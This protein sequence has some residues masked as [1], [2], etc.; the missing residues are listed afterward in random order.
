MYR[1]GFRRRRGWF[2]LLLAVVL[3]A[4]VENPVTGERELGF[5][6]TAQQIA[7]GE[8]QYVPAQQ[9]QGGQYVVDPQLSA[10]VQRVGE[11]VAA[12]SGIDLP[13]EFVV[14]NSSVPNAWALPGGK[15]AINRGLLTELSNEAE[16]A[17]VLGHEITHAAARH[18]AKAIERGVVAQAA[19]LGVAIGV[20]DTG[21]A[22]AALGAAQLAAGLINQKYGRNAERESDYYGTRMMAEAGYDPYAAVTLQEKFVRLSQG[23]DPSWLEGLFASHPPS[24]ERVANNRQLVQELRAQGFTGGE[25]N[26]DAYQNALRPLRRDAEAYA[27]YDEARKALAEGYVEEAEALVAKAIERQ[28]KEPAFHSLRGEIR[29]RQERYDDALI[30]FERALELDDGFYANHLGR[31]VALARQGQPQAARQSLQSSLQL[32]PT[33]VAYHELGVLAERAGDLD[34][35][36]SHYQTAA[37]SDSPAGQAARTRLLR[38]DLPR[39]PARYVEAAL[40]RDAGGRLVMQVSNR[41]GAPLE[42]IEVVVDTLDAAGQRRRFGRRVAQLG[43]GAASVVLVAEGAEDLVDARATV[44]GARLAR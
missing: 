20:G 7:I 18:G 15:L 13:Y 8:Q 36:L 27:A 26:A 43:A 17:A 10:Y 39:N 19:M 1:R 31:G 40:A 25:F 41:T 38:L 12:H 35:A 14:L 42:D 37:Q 3:A 22:N 28:G 6:S 44:V 24:T 23:H 9:M 29:L 11:R 33:A 34:T 4:C 21:Y 16:L 2:L 32:L 5:V 30:N